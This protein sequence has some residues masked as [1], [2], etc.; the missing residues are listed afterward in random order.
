MHLSA[1]DPPLTCQGPFNTYG[2]WALAHPRTPSHTRLPRV[3]CLLRTRL[4][5]PDH[6]HHHRQQIDISCEHLHASA[7]PSGHAPAVSQ[8]QESQATGTCTTSQ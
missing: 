2:T 4:R 7:L 8:L 1:K 5:H 3:A 6:H